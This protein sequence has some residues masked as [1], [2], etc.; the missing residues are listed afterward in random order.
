MGVAAAAG[1][2]A[3]GSFGGRRPVIFHSCCSWTDSGGFREVGSAASTAGTG[4]GR[5]FSWGTFTLARKLFKF[6]FLLSCFV[7]FFN[8]ILLHRKNQGKF[9]SLYFVPP[10]PFFLKESGPLFLLPKI[11][12]FWHFSLRNASKPANPNPPERSNGRND[13]PRPLPAPIS[14]FRKKQNKVPPPTHQPTTRHE[15]TIKNF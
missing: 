14:S 5:T 1:E 15:I 9:S 11:T 3:G 10:S 8:Y 2:V 12:L 6:F 4:S 7:D 13:P